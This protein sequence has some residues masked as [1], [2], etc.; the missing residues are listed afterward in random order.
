M[1]LF[2]SRKL[3]ILLALTLV[4]TSFSFTAMAAEGDVVVKT[5]DTLGTVTNVSNSLSDEIKVHT[6][7][8]YDEI[9][10]QNVTRYASQAFPDKNGTFNTAGTEARQYLVSSSG[11]QLVDGSKKYLRIETDIKITNTKDGIGFR[12]G[13]YG[14]DGELLDAGVNDK[15]TIIASD[16]I[17]LIGGSEAT[18]SST[19]NGFR[20][21]SRTLETGKWHHVVM[22]LGTATDVDTV[23]F[24]VDGQQV[25]MSAATHGNEQVEDENGKVNHPTVDTDGTAHY[26]REGYGF[27]GA[28]GNRCVFLPTS[29][30]GLTLDTRL[31]DFTMTATDTAYDPS[32]FVAKDELLY[33][34]TASSKYTAEKYERVAVEFSDFTTPDFDADYKTATAK[35]TRA[36]GM[37]DKNVNSSP[38]SEFRFSMLSPEGSASTPIIDHTKH[39][40]LRIMFNVYIKDASNSVY[41]RTLRTSD[42]TYYKTNHNYTFNVGGSAATDP[43]FTGDA[44]TYHCINYNGLSVGEWH[45]VVMDLGTGGNGTN[46]Q[47]KI[48]VDGQS[49]DFLV[50]EQSVENASFGTIEKDEATKSYGFGT[51]SANF[52]IF[53]VKN[54]N[55]QPM[56]VYLSDLSV[57]AS[58]SAHAPAAAPSIDGV[59]NGGFTYRVDTENKAITYVKDRDTDGMSVADFKVSNVDYVAPTSDNQK[60]IAYNDTSKR[61]TYYTLAE[62][63]DVVLNGVQAEIG[64]DGRLYVKFDYNKEESFKLHIAY[65]KNDALKFLRADTWCTMPAG[66][67]AATYDFSLPTTV[68]Y[69]EIR[70]FA[71]RSSGTGTP[72]I[73]P[74]LKSAEID[75]VE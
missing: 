60:V 46:D 12:M 51:Y 37:E 70:V 45:N 40:I 72:I 9:L 34:L 44:E 48:Y 13:R 65:Y 56:E 66:L 24:Y 10:G 32:T 49:V 11:G 62:Q 33:K 35:I 18:V 55:K 67:S 41:F 73:I 2:K 5:I 63:P 42:G 19:S 16:N 59:P 54:A 20:F 58:N 17:F 22:E 29:Y 4:L 8:V 21:Y 74:V 28:S 68:D 27:G 3:S 36:S 64:E 6:E 47:I 57:K 26:V 30:K 61:V 25:Q 14:E 50:D 15:G 75:V 7:T 43:G 52:C 69:D 53:G 31:S 23:K 1:K 71:W 39:D 38:A